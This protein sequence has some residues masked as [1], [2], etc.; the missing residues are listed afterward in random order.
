MSILAY[1]KT[2]SRLAFRAKH[3]DAAS[4]VVREFIVMFYPDDRTIEIVDVNG[5]K[6]FLKRCAVP[7]L[8]TSHFFIGAEVVLV[9]RLFMITD[10]ADKVTQQLCERVAEDAIV[11]V[12]GD[13]LVGDSGRILD[14]VTQEC[15]F[16]IR[17][18][19]ILNLRR[20]DWNNHNNSS[21][22]NNNN[23]SYHSTYS[24]SF[25]P[26]SF[27]DS[28]A[29]ILYLIRNQA[30]SKVTSLPERISK[31]DPTKVW[32]TSSR[33][34]VHAA[35]GLF[36]LAA[37]SRPAALFNNTNTTVVA[38]KPT[39]V[40]QSYGG[41]IIRMILE[42]ASSSRY[43]YPLKITAL[44]QVA[45]PMSRADL[46]VQPLKGVVQEFRAIVE[47]LASGPMWVMQLAPAAANS[48]AS[49]AAAGVSVVSIV[50][51]I[52]GP[53]DPVV[54]KVLRPHTVR[55]KFGVNVVQNAVHCCDL[56]DDG[57]DDTAVLWAKPAL[58]HLKPSFETSMQS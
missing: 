47:D 10:Y 27:A 39:A 3:L 12:S 38:I 37:V 14:V 31:R 48:R 52:C 25:L 41:E 5:K 57:P 2:D 21:N 40:A 35:S 53:Y 46:Y 28:P 1:S 36:E 43:N 17:S 33:E 22:D 49:A 8:S 4:N 55:A 11:V 20:S 30:L 56:E 42:T 29:L 23:S 54:A 13:S 50:R 45:L 16:H 34:D 58:L 18:M 26:Q 6:Q 44:S 24:A 51:D 7:T 32:V 19:H 15:G 9:G